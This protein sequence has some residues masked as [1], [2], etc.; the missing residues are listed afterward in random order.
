MMPIATQYRQ[1]A[2]SVSDN[3]I[4]TD[5]VEIIAYAINDIFKI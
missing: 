1:Q 4:V 2:K 5:L 3:R